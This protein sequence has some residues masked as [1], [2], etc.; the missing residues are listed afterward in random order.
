MRPTP[1][2]AAS[3]VLAGC[4]NEAIPLRDLATRHQITTGHVISRDCANH[5]AIYYSFVAG[6]RTQAGRAPSGS[7]NCSAISVGDP[8]TV[9][10]DPANPTEYTLKEPRLLYEEKRGFYVPVRLAVPLLFMLVF[11]ATVFNARFRRVRPAGMEPMDG[12]EA[13][14]PVRKQDE[15]RR[16][17]RA[18][19]DTWLKSPSAAQ[20]AL[21]PE[22]HEIVLES[23]TGGSHREGP[24]SYTLTRFLRN[25]EGRYVLF[26]STPSGPYVKL[27]ADDVAKAALKA[28]WVAPAR[29]QG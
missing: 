27:I 3:L 6:G 26:K 24:D 21:G 7:L 25:A 13:S 14:R 17:A 16:F 2:I 28:R 1:L 5:G 20:L 8:V 10:Y 15:H 12:R 19:F 23:E 22:Q 4:Y 18:Q 9:Y 29:H 11:A